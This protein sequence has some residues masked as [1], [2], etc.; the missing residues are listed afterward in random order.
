MS[1]PNSY[2]DIFKATTIFGGAQLFNIVVAL[3]KNKFVAILLG[4]T[5]YGINGLLTNPISLISTISGMGLSASSVRDISIS[6][7]NGT[8][9][10][11]CRTL[12]VFNKLLWLTGLLGTLLVVILSPILSCLSFGDGS[13]TISFIILSFT[14]L[15]A[16]FTQ[17]YNGVLRGLRMTRQAA[18]IYTAAPFASTVFTIPIYYFWGIK[19]IVP[20]LFLSSL[21]SLLITWIYS[22]KIPYKAL[23]V[24]YKEA[25]KEGKGMIGLGISM[26]TS[27][28]MTQISGYIIILVVSNFG[29][30][31]EVGFYTAGYAMVN[32]SV[33][34]V[35]SAVGADYAPR[36]AAIQDDNTKIRH[37]ASQQCEILLILL[38]P[39]ITIFISFLP[40]FVKIILTEDF[41]KVIPFVSITAIAM[42]MRAVTWS[43]SFIFP[44]KGDSKYFLFNEIFSGIISTAIMCAGYIVLGLKG[45]GI[46]FLLGNIFT[47]SIIYYNSQKRYGFSYS[48]IVLKLFLFSLCF[49]VLAMVS[50]MSLNSFVNYGTY[51]LSFFSL[52]FCIKELK[53]R[54][55]I[56]KIKK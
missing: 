23:K 16:I 9:E 14:V 54:L 47:F 19:G 25:I 21:L 44:A 40:L 55:D 12:G 27:D 41:V 24:T 42:L 17:G 7:S 22:R 6:N 10:D 46:G 28:I 33:G 43:V 3:V 50:A 32:I 2:Y 11:I 34:L 29:S 52:F 49:P 20:V 48:I 56:L 35:F 36:L 8:K 5:G 53:K 37:L 31:E 30:I 45:A 13:Y 1:S 26:A 38:S 18:I 4:A 51:F 15:F 39:I